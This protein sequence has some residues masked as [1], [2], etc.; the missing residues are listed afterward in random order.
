MT[1][2]I[3]LTSLWS[4]RCYIFCVW[5][6]RLPVSYR[7]VPVPGHPAQSPA[8][9][10]SVS[11]LEQQQTRMGRP[12][13]PYIAT[14]PQVMRR[15]RRAPEVSCQINTRKFRQLKPPHSTMWGKIF[16]LL[17]LP[18][19]LK[20]LISQ[21]QVDDASWSWASAFQKCNCSMIT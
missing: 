12:I 19:P 4:H 14:T 18:R 5:V 9:G 13:L 16:L 11:H 15:S 10:L 6:N 7:I 1:K 2:S 17:R 20:I 3:T 21:S 8:L